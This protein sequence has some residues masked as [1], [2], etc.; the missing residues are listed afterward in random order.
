VL[1]ALFFLLTPI[2][3][4]TS[5]FTLFVLNNEPNA[6]SDVAIETINKG[7]PEGVSVYAS[8]P[9]KTPTV[10]GVAT[11]SDSRVRL[12][13]R[14]MEKNSSPL[15]GYADDVVETSD[16]YGI[17]WRLLAAIAQKESGLCRVIPD[18]SYNCW[19]WGVHSKGTL[20]FENW[21]DAITTVARGLK[22]KY[23]DY[24]LVTPE[25]IMTKYIPHSPNGVWAVDVQAYMDDIATL[26]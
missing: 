10:L 15:A 6:A 12:L 8:L 19:G 2:A 4:G 14:Y 21:E 7:V 16:K 18:D 17:D 13:E 25:E 22:E 23:A 26:N 24:G 11:S 3:I 9:S 5:L 20:R 1:V